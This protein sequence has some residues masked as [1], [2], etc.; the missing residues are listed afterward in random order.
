M[1]REIITRKASDNPYLH[2]D[3]HG[4]L[5]A[6]I[7]YLHER[8]GEQAV[9][10]YLRQFARAFY[11][12]LTVDLNTRGLVALK[13][14]FERIYRVEGAEVRLRLSRDELVVEVPRCPAV[15]HM[16]EHGY[17]VARLFAETT[18]TVGEAVC[19]GTPFWAEMMEYDEESGR[20]VQR[21]S[22]RKP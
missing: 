21:F 12:P 5:S 13:E 10:D 7:E 17:K 3:F 9:R 2:K 8:H 4:A 1:P 16:R 15:T 19:E 6:G 14:H 22:R 11:G 20:S 18:R